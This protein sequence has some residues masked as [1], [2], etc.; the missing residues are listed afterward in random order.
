MQQKRSIDVVMA[1]EKYY[2]VK[3]AKPHIPRSSE[4]FDIVR[5]L[6][7]HKP[8]HTQ[9]MREKVAQ[10]FSKMGGEGDAYFRADG[11]EL[12]ETMLILYGD[13]P[14]HQIERVFWLAE[15]MNHASIAGMLTRAAD[16]ETPRQKENRLIMARVLEGMVDV[17]WH[18]QMLEKELRGNPVE[19]A[20]I[21]GLED[22]V[23]ALA[24]I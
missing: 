13:K 19:W 11:Y 18:R 22:V 4:K 7:T 24:S 16:E 15:N 23:R 6:L 12:A 10:L 21:E 9:N 5:V 17:P 3:Y 14:M 20:G 1:S 8:Q 2:Q